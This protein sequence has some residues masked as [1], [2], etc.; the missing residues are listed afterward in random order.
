MARKYAPQILMLALRSCR[1]HMH[2]S[3]ALNKP[4]PNEIGA[5]NPLDSDHYER[6]DAVILGVKL[7]TSSST[8]SVSKPDPHF[9]LVLTVSFL[10]SPRPNSSF[11]ISTG[12]SVLDP[13]FDTRGAFR[14]VCEAD[15][16]Q[17]LRLSPETEPHYA[18]QPTENR[19]LKT[20]EWLKF[21]TIPASGTVQIELPLPLE[22]ILRA[23]DDVKR[24]DMKPGTKYRVWMKQALL[25]FPYSYWGNLGGDL[26]DKKLSDRMSPETGKLSEAEE[27]ECKA[28]ERKGWVFDQGRVQ[29]LGNVGRHGPEFV[30]EE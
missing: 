14:L 9:H 2:F 17:S 10:H 24:E 22:R 27:D 29:A 19:D 1:H 20:I 12:R 25:H 5:D 28:L 21:I 4:H 13:D 26:K 3:P 8:L 11:T 15:E 7:S 30:L 6:S 23:N 16:K 18:Y